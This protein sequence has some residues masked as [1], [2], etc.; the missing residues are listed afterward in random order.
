[1]E[2]SKNLK[3]TRKILANWQ[4][5]WYVLWYNIHR[6]WI[7]ALNSNFLIPISLQPESKTK[8]RK[9]ST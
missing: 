4:K 9:A 6:N 2:I 8:E 3:M 1:M 5:N 7:L